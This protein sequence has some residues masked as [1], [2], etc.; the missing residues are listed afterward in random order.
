MW[1]KL[2]REEFLD[3]AKAVVGGLA[4]ALYGYE[5]IPEEW[6]ADLLKGDFIES[7]CEVAFPA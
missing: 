4:G 5:A 7:L 2:S 1:K 3:K 6:R